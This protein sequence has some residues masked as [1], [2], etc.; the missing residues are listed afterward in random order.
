MHR[1]IVS[2]SVSIKTKISFLLIH[3]S[4]GCSAVV[5][6]WLTFKVFS[7]FCISYEWQPNG[8]KVS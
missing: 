1:L 6:V 3:V 7:V 8:L 4:M 5:C 2:R